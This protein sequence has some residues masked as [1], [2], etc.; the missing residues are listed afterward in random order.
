MQRDIYTGN[1]RPA[2]KPVEPIDS[3]LTRG[4][5]ESGAQFSRCMRYRYLLWR[6]W[7]HFL[8][9]AVFILMNPSTADEVDNDPTVERCY[10][11]SLKWWSAGAHGGVGGIVVLNVYAWRETNSKELLPLVKSGAD[12]IGKRND[13]F[14]RYY[15]SR[16]AIVVCGWG[17]E[18]EMGGRGRA[19][20]NTL[21]LSG[22]T[23]HAFKINK[24]GS[25]K[26][27]LYVAYETQPTPF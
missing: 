26:H 5:S 13:D 22:V 7:D 9:P 16:A 14:I 23:P 3:I 10:Q 19:V 20:L 24:D 6:T 2:D 1:D 8:K 4:S 18:G 15:A 27:P 25:P 21:R 17:K 12:I 11:R